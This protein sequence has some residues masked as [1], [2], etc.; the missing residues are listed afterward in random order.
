[1]PFELILLQLR[2]AVRP[3]RHRLCVGLEVDVVVAL[4][5]WW[6]PFGL[7]KH[8]GVSFQQAVK[9]GTLGTLVDAE[10]GGEKGSRG[11]LCRCAHACPHHLATTDRERHA[12]RCEVPEMGPSDRSHVRPRTMSYG[13]RG[14]EKQSIVNR[15]EPMRSW[16]P[17]A[18]P[19]QSTRSLFATMTWAPALS[20]N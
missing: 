1:M 2:I 17:R 6:E 13:A 18:R 3:D 15:S 4:T 5:S 14:M 8:V 7:S 19:W 10:V 11:R 16:T 12:E 20:A 9:E